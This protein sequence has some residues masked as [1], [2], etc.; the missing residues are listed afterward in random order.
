MSIRKVTISGDRLDSKTFALQKMICA[1]IK[2][3]FHIVF[4]MH[5]VQA[6]LPLGLTLRLSPSAEK[7][8]ASC[9]LVA[10]Q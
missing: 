8:G 5:A 1:T 6:V 9:E 4:Q 10:L 3:L 7:G 2:L